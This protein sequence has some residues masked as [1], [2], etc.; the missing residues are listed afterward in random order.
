M[1]YPRLRGCGPISI[2]LET[3]DP[4]LKT[5]GPGWATGDG[6]VAGI[7]VA[8]GG[9]AAYYGLRHEGGGNH[10]P[11]V[12]SKWIEEELSGPELKI[13]HN[14]SYDLGWLEREGVTVRGPIFDT[15]IAEK[16]INENAVSHSLQ[17]VATKY[18]GEGKV[19]E[20]MEAYLLQHFGRRTVKGELS[21][22]GNSDIKGQIWRAPADIVAAYAVG[23]VRLPRQIYPLQKKILEAE[24][25]TDVMEL[26]MR[27][28]RILNAMR[29]RG[30]A[31]DV[32]RAEQLRDEFDAR[33]AAILAQL[34][35]VTGVM[36]ANQIAALFTSA[37]I[38]CGLTPTG[39]PSVTHAFLQTVRHDYARMILEAREL[40][41]L[42][43][44][45]IKSYIIEGNHDGRI[46][47]SFN[48][49]G[50]RTGRM[51]CVAAW[52]EVDTPRGKREIQHLRVGDYVY[53]HRERWRRVTH[54]W[55]KGID[56]MLKLSFS[57]GQSL[58]CTRDHKLLTTAG[59]KKV[60]EIYERFKEVGKPAGEY[61]GL[62][63]HLSE[64]LNDGG[65]NRVGVRND[66]SQ[67]PPHFEESSDAGGAARLLFV[68][69]VAGA[70]TDKW[71]EGEKQR[72][73]SQ[74]EGGLPDEGRLLHDTRPSRGQ[75]TSSSFCVYGSDGIVSHPD[76]HGDTSHRRR[77]EQQC[78][79][80]F[81]FGHEEGAQNY[82]F[83]S[84]TGAGFVTI[85][86]IDCV[87]DFEVYDITVEEDESYAACGV[88]SHNSSNPNLQNIPARTE[89]GSVLREMF[90]P[91]DGCDFFS[92]DFS[93]VEYRI[94]A[95]DAYESELEG[96]DAVVRR[97]QEDPDVDYHQI[98]ADMTGLTRKQAKTINFACAYGAGPDKI[99]EQMG[100]PRGEAD[101]V[102]G[103][104][105]DKAPFLRPLA[106]SATNIALR[107][108][109]IGTFSGRRRHYNLW[110]RDGVIYHQ[111]VPRAKLA[112]TH[113]ALNSRIQGSAA[114]VMKYAVVA[115]ED[116]GVLDVIN[117]SLLVH[118]EAAGSVPKT[119]E[120]QEALKEMVNVMENT[121]QLSV[122]LRV[123]C[124]TGKNWGD[125]K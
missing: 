106:R 33:K 54:T 12:V 53:T 49:L 18:L 122:P 24:G 87:G 50:A 11:A 9:F 44:T 104:Y 95:H 102:L 47:A 36:N 58:V 110:E 89:T 100:V 3:F 70:E 13:G 15:M 90:V 79:G 75:D 43:N 7:A 101:R 112:F 28:L 20:E 16:L 37:G 67:R 6:F 119:K 84:A 96:A 98:V 8:A 109:W 5:H 113:A 118:D 73:T 92:A 38:T 64:G 59:W 114:D 78:A 52:T 103:I 46:H 74:L 85:E 39:K 86:E 82:S 116:A 27:L 108:R 94:L 97:Y 17:A 107:E 62:S 14:L 22:V 25:T 61:S 72:A 83:P 88:F 68:E 42:S 2:D 34:P 91:D 57:D 48:Q 60:G 21:K 66:V 120:G 10:D 77:P 121:T 125:A 63:E 40:E 117:V 45:F 76:G 26:E 4:R 29:R 51:S 56:N 30:V 32:R 124:N 19:Q 55:I 69:Q 80:Q 99:A 41:K 31:V 115:M 65:E 81:G 35:G 71:N 1:T 111:P 23:D 93:Q 123:D 105:H